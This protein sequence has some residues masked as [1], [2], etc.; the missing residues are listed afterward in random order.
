MEKTTLGAWL[1]NGLSYLT[2]ALQTNQTLQIIQLIV[3]ILA[4]VVAIS[5]TI[6]KWYKKASADGKITLEEI[7]E[8][9]EDIKNEITD[10]QE[11]T[12]EEKEK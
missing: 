3:S 4:S 8:L 12:K 2:T 6:W 9:H 1:L 10:L 5:F 7:E 11:S